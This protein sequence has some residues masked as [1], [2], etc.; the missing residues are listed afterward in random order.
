MP[1]SKYMPFAGIKLFVVILAVFLSIQLPYAGADQV[2]NVVCDSSRDQQSPAIALADEDSYLI[3]WQDFRSGESFDI[4]GAGMNDGLAFG[5]DPI[6]SVPR[7]QKRPAVA[8]DG[9]HYVVIW[10][11][12]RDGEFYDIYGVRIAKN[13]ALMDGPANVSGKPICTVSD[14]Q[15]NPQLVWNNKDCFLVVWED[16][17]NS[18]ADI[19]G[20]RVATDLKL[21][22]GPAE[23]SGFILC[24]MV[25]AQS[26][27]SV[28]WNGTNFFVVWEDY[29]S[30]DASDIRGL[31]ISPAGKILDDVWGG[32][33]PVSLENDIQHNPCVA[34]DGESFLVV[35]DNHTSEDWYPDIYGIKVSNDGQVSQD[36]PIAISTASYNQVNP[37]VFW[38]ENNY[39]CLWKD[40]RDGTMDVY[41]TRINSTGELLNGNPEKGGIALGLDE[42]SFRYTRTGAG[43]FQ[44]KG[45]VVWEQYYTGE[46]DLYKMELVPPVPPLLSWAGEP[47]YE[48]DGVEPDTGYGGETFTFKVLYKDSEATPPKLAQLW[49]DM[50]GDG[51]FESLDDQEINMGLAPEEV[52][53]DYAIGVIYQAEIPL[54]YL[55]ENGVAYR[56]YFKDDID[57]AT[58]PPSEVSEVIVKNNPPVIEWSDR[59]GYIADGVDPD[60]AEG[61]FYFQF[62]VNYRDIEGDF[63]EVAE[64]W[65]DMDDS[66]TYEQRERF[67]M[68][69][70][71]QEAISNGRDY[72]KKIQI[73]YAGDGQINYRFLFTD[74]YHLAVGDP[75]Q[76]DPTKNHTLRVLPHLMAPI[77]SWPL[78]EDFQDGV[79][80]GTGDEENMF[81][82]KVGYRDPDN[83][84]PV[85]TQVWLDLNG[86][87]IFTEDE[88]FNMAP[89]GIQDVDFT[90]V[91]YYILQKALSYSG[92]GEM[93]YKFMF[94]DGWNIATGDPFLVGG[95]IMVQSPIYL[96]WSSEEA[97]SSDGVDPDSGPQGTPFEFRIIYVNQ[98]G[99]PPSVKEVWLD[100]NLDGDFTETERY[101]MEDADP[102][103]MIYT[104]GKEYVKIIQYSGEETGLIP[105][106]FVFRDIY[107]PATGSPSSEGFS[108]Q[109]LAEGDSGISGWDQLAW[110]A[111]QGD[112]A[113]CF[114]RILSGTEPISLRPGN[115]L[116]DI[117]PKRGDPLIHLW[118]TVLKFGLITLLIMAVICFIMFGYSMLRG[119]WS[120]AD[121]L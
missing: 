91:N 111:V 103:D 86:D 27:P 18:D 104:D 108:I 106:R 9:S 33:I 64:V 100:E 60:E 29:V 28:A 102:S 87:G 62:I 63:P 71:D 35:W 77:L 80:K 83:D 115:E 23:D 51:A 90:E 69:E 36:E 57:V 48:S 56:F 38:T 59:A 85:T 49:I 53:P 44:A 112:G 2:G 30:D 7:D 120:L 58:G 65:V 8:W 89:E 110:D 113:G 10:E 5:P 118:L 15:I 97:F 105:Y 47:G 82:F 52:S 54:E 94:D 117:R 31:R 107:M 21:F 37:S 25:G 34:S 43:F 26:K 46:L 17:R 16:Y 75:N 84:S 73:L 119:G 14:D 121:R 74:G 67:V 79:N 81:T 61:S 101:S 22:E 1:Y 114:I 40:D 68:S 66:Q 4:Y 3:V 72:K 70:A 45:I 55:S 88:R 19:Y 13:G 78:D 11:D 50:D 109:V 92:E 98:N 39:I 24:Q 93:I 41:W 76:D 99:Y 20:L 96:A 95:T 32:G 12:D 42:E 116:D 6:C